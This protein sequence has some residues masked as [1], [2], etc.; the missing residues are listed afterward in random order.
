MEKEK[1]KELIVSQKERF[2]AKR[3]LLPRDIQIDIRRF[4]PQREM[5]ILTG[6]R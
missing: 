1:L 6:V 2:L 5:I 4:L 3:G